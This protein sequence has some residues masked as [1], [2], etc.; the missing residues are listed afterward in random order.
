MLLFV[1][2]LPM[3]YPQLQAA[4][5]AAL[6]ANAQL[7]ANDEKNVAAINFIGPPICTEMWSVRI[8]I[9]PAA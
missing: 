2:F 5:N 4:E 8:S 9:G 3:M 7:D 1:S 6:R